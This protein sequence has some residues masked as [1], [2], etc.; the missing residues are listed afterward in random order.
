MLFRGNETDPVRRVR[1]QVRR[2]TQLG[3]QRRGF[4]EPGE[5]EGK[6]DCGEA[7]KLCTHRGGVIL[8][9]GNIYNLYAHKREATKRIIVRAF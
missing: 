5:V 1:S 2:K 8:E 4:W 7:K 6:L 9:D 3:R